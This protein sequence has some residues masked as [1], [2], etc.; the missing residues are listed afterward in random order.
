MGVT[1][2]RFPGTREE[3]E[4]QF[5]GV[6][7]SPTTNGEFLYKTG[8]GFEFYDEGEV[9]RLGI[10]TDNHHETDSIVH[11]IAEDSY[12]EIIYVSGK[13][14]SETVYTDNTKTVKI[15]ETSIT[16]DGTKISQTVT[17]QYDSSGSPEE[18]YTEDYTYNTSDQIVLV[19]GVLT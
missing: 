13:I 11:N 2:D 9:K 19:D 16:Y 3:S 7:N 1:P 8:S 10:S 4:I 12:T 15:R 18:T 14:S 5:E 17:I 6:T